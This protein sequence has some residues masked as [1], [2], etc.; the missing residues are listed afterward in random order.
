[1]VLWRQGHRRG[2]PNTWGRVSASKASHASCVVLSL[3]APIPFDD[4]PCFHS[5]TCAFHPHNTFRAPTIEQSTITYESC[6]SLKYS[7]KHKALFIKC[8]PD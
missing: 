3:F 2:C 7:V 1:M 4:F 5:F 8:F 6:F